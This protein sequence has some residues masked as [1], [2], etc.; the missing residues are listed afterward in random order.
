[1][2]EVLVTTEQSRQHVM[3]SI[4][5]VFQQNFPATTVEA[6][7]P[8][9]PSSVQPPQQ[10]QAAAEQNKTYL[11]KSLQQTMQKYENAIV[12][13]DE[14]LKKAP[15]TKPRN[16][17]S[18]DALF[19]SGAEAGV[20]RSH[21][22]TFSAPQMEQPM[23]PTKGSKGQPKAGNGGEENDGR[24]ALDFSRAENVVE[25]CNEQALSGAETISAL[26]SIDQRL[27]VSVLLQLFQFINVQSLWLREASAQVALLTRGSEET[28]SDFEM[29]QRSVNDA[30]AAA[31]QLDETN[32]HR[33]DAVHD[34]LHVRKLR[35]HDKESYGLPPEESKCNVLFDGTVVGNG[36]DAKKSEDGVKSPKEEVPVTDVSGYLYVRL[37][38][39]KKVWKRRYCTLDGEQGF[40]TV[41]TKSGKE[42]R[43]SL[44]VLLIACK[45]GTKSGMPA[46][47]FELVTPKEGTHSFIAWSLDTVLCWQTAFETTRARVLLH[48]S[49]GQ[50]SSSPTTAQSTSTAN[51]LAEAAILF[52][53]SA[54]LPKSTEEDEEE[55]EAGAPPTPEKAKSRNNLVK[56][57]YLYSLSPANAVCADCGAPDPE[58]TSL[59]YGCLVCLQCA[60]IHRSLGVQISKIRSLLLDDVPNDGF[61][62]IAAIGNE[63]CRNVL[64]RFI[65]GNFDRSVLRTSTEAR[66]R[67][68]LAKYG[69]K[70]FAARSALTADRLNEE[71]HKAVTENDVR[72]VMFYHM[73]GA[74]LSQEEAEDPLLCLAIE[75]GFVA[76]ASY[77]LANG[78]DPNVQDGRMWTP[79]HYAVEQNN[80]EVVLMLLHYGA[81]LHAKDQLGMTPADI[82]VQRHATECLSL[83][84]LA[85]SDE[86]DRKLAQRAARLDEI[87]YGSQSEEQQQRTFASLMDVFAEAGATSHFEMPP[88]SGLKLT[89]VNIEDIMN[90]DTG[91]K[92]QD[93][94]KEGEQGKEDDRDDSDDGELPPHPETDAPVPPSLQN[95]PPHPV[96]DAPVPPSLLES[97]SLPERPSTE[98]PKPNSPPS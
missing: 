34:N 73:S 41:W 45:R 29:L 49:D 80:T 74:S 9:S 58:W 87:V 64:E 5:S 85:A 22:R 81:D 70:A 6:G 28:E 30:R 54:T 71:L 52:N 17:T 63:H 44:N 40:F 50:D 19:T 67:F 48:Y 51:G 46:T 59:Q 26:R 86:K 83:L 21:M 93:A 20:T 88:D 8:A 78:A 89:E 84:T 12:V 4:Q 66:T 90:S 75:E 72:A 16:V 91:A 33:M 56:L 61:G 23:S 27:N 24:R 60:G 31:N 79:L 77:L 1:M 43:F 11:P 35:A 94:P 96:T 82:G 18:N 95:V 62:L 32:K 7:A 55:E 14:L 47:Y 13:C 92:K 15:G 98:A 2:L 53:E 68:I 69:Q 57:R 76:V 97:V 42:A 36:F 38:R 39:R 65:P 10:Q 3:D 37:G 25:V